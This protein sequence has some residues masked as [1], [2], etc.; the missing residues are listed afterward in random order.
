LQQD[1]KEK[2]RFEGPDTFAALEDIDIE[3]GNDEREYKNVS[4]R[5]STYYEL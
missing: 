2:Y 3:V 5:E 4:Q 1:G